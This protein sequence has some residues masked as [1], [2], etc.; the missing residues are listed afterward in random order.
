MG[1]SSGGNEAAAR[2]QGRIDKELAAE[3]TLADRPNQYNRFGS[4]EWVKNPD[5]SWTQTQE[6]SGDVN[7]LVDQ[8]L[9]NMRNRGMMQGAAYNRAQDAMSQ[10]ADW[11]QFGEAQDFQYNAGD[12]R[13]R[14]EDAAYQRSTRRLDPQF[15]KDRKALDLRLRQQ[16]LRA[17][18]KAYDNQMGNFN[19]RRNDAYENARLNSVGVGRQE[20][21]QDWQQQMQSTNYA[22]SLRDKRIQEYDMKR[23]Y[24]LN[25]FDAISKAGGAKNALEYVQDIA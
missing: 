23:K 12:I 14:A 13:Q 3:K 25:E 1:K 21:A 22:N 16:G 17:G 15:E 10:P 5:G 2:E 24:G 8:D 6:L 18:D 7:S 11:E 19:N 9:A 20:A 4:L